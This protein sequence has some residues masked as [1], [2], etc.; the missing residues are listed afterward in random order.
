M[1]QLN[2]LKQMG[3]AF[4]IGLLILLLSL[5]LVTT[6]YYFNLLGSKV[7]SIMELLIP[8][9]TCFISGILVGKKASNKGWLAGLEMG[10]V[11]FIFF[12]LFAFLGL[13]HKFQMTNIL[14]YLVMVFASTFGGMIGIGYKKKD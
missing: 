5:F 3:I 9:L 12:L 7:F 2:Q 8:L 14:F 10:F 6:L 4:G 11:Y 13:Q 1:K